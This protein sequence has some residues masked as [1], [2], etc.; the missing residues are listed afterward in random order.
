VSPLFSGD[1]APDVLA[2]TAERAY[3]GIVLIWS[4][5]RVSAGQCRRKQ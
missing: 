4:S 5:Q 1:E 2:I 3:E